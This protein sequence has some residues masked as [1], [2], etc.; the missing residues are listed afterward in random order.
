MGKKQNL[1]EGEAKLTIWEPQSLNGPP[2]D[3]SGWDD[4]SYNPY[5]YQSLNVGCSGEGTILC[6]GILLSWGSQS[7]IGLMD[8]PIQ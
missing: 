5:F 3:A 1:V 7:L 2:E 6:E 4:K 8:E